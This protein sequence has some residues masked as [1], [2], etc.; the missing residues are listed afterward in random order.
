MAIARSNYINQ[1]KLDIFVGNKLLTT[2]TGDGLLIATPTG[3]T[4]YSLS[5]GGPIVH[6]SIRAMIIV[7]ISPTSL[8][9]RPVVLPTK[10]PL[11]IRVRIFVKKISSE[12]RNDGLLSLDG[13]ANWKFSKGDELVVSES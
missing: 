1:I 8:S 9:F 13:Q 11:K 3:S 6:S 10:L 12:S 4:A 7:P 2:V 5:A